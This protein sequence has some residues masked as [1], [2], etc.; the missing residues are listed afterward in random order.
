MYIYT[1]GK[2]TLAIKLLFAFRYNELLLLT[3]VSNPLKHFFTNTTT[4]M[5]VFV[6]II[7]RI[8]MEYMCVFY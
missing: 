1:E 3:S 5:H 8:K 7:H 6:Y 2:T 4:I